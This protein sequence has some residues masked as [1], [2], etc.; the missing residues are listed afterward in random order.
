MQRYFIHFAYDG[1]RYHG[2]QQ[3]PNAASVQQTLQQ[4]LST[5]QRRQVD[6]VGA[7]R[8]DT[9]VHAREMVAHFDSPETIDT[10]QLVYRLNRLLPSDISVTSLHPVDN[11][12]HARFSARARTYHYY[13][14][15]RKNPFLHRYSCY[16]TYPLDFNLMNQAAAHLLTVSDFAAFCK[17]HTDVKT[18]LCQVTEA[19]WVQ[20][21]PSQWHFV[22]TANRFLRNMVRAIVGTLIDVGRGRITVDQ[23]VHIVSMQKRTEAGE[24]MPAHALFLEKIEY[25]SNSQCRV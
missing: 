8:T 9:G 6:V 21:S 4:A 14:H 10:S 11:D 25:L 24:S 19:R 20:D 12:M 3:Q 22:I 1:L 5:I 15:T 17:S 18:T 2:W 7:G 16:L 13:V 23:F